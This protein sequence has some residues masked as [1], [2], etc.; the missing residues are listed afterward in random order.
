MNKFNEA[1]RVQMPAMIHLMRLGYSY[2]GKISEEDAGTVYDPSTNILTDVFTS[3]FAKLNPDSAGQAKQILQDI[4]NELK[5]D[6][7]GFAFYQRLKTIS[8]VKIIDYDNPANNLFH[9]TAEFTYKNGQDEFR[10]DITLF[11]NGLPLVFI[12]VKKPNNSGGMVAESRRMNLQRFP[13][14]RFRSFINITQLMI[15]S[16]NMEYDAM[17]GIVPLQ[18]AFYCT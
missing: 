14:K 7:L 16:N 18:G 2:F 4:R 10:P 9:F 6:D 3:Q 15:F 13:N 8:P 12:E 5:N 11:V 1:T 17:G